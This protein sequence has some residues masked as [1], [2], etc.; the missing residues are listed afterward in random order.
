MLDQEPLLRLDAPR[1]EVLDQ[2]TS[3]VRAAW[4]SFDQARPGQPGLDDV[5]RRLLGSPLPELPTAASAALR[6]TA[7]VLDESIAPARPR[8]FA[9]VGSSGLEIG[10]V[11]DALAAC[12]DVN[13]ASY[14]GAATAIEREVL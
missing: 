7:R 3:I 2:A 9:F 5:V 11:A 13:L 8:Y 6:D 10:V 12:F 1:E 4:K 14:G